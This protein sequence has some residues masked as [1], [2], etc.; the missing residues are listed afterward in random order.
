MG[1]LGEMFQGRK[2]S[3]EAG[4]TDGWKETRE[5]VDSTWRSINS[6]ARSN[7]DSDI[8]L[9]GS[10]L[11]VVTLAVRVIDARESISMNGS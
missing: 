6:N 8:S 10:S 3:S 11:C 2:E 1:S 4:R 9:V 7:N 5:L